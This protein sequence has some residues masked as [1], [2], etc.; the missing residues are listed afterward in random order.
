[1]TPYLPSLSLTSSKTEPN[2]PG[3]GSI[4]IFLPGIGEIQTVYD[5]LNDTRLFGAHSSDFRLIPLHSTL[6]SEEQ[7]LIFKRMQK[8]KIILSTNIAET[9]IT[10]DDVTFVIDCGLSKIKYFDNNKNMESLETAWISRANVAQRKGRSGRSRSG[11]SFHLF[12]RHRFE[13]HLMAQQ[14][15]EIHRIPLE[16]LLLR[17]K[18]LKLFEKARVGDV[19]ARCIEPPTLDNVDGAVKRL[20]NLGALE[21]ERLTPLGSHLAL[22]PVDVRI[23]KLMLFGAIFQCLDSILTIC[24]CLSH[25]SPFVSP[26]TKR[27]EADAR[28]KQFAIGNSDHLTVLNAY[29]RWKEANARSAYAGKVFAEENFLS[30][31]TLE[32]IAEIKQQ[33]VKLLVEI[34]FVPVDLSGEVRRRKKKFEDNVLEVT[35]KMLNANFGNTR[36]ISG[37]LSASLYPNVIKILT[38]EKNYINTI[39]GA[40]PRSFQASEIKFKTKEDGYVALHPSSINANVGVFHSPFLVYQEKVK[41][42]RIFIRD[43][44]MVQVIPLILFSGTDIRIEMHDNEF[45][46]ILEDGWLIVQADSLQTAESMK[47]LRRELMNILNEKIKDPLLNLWNHE[48]GKRVVSAIIHLLTK[49]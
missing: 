3:D 34:G 11:I 2:W 20:Q 19:L 47:Y 23:G 22:L 12:S 5:H 45:L 24:A 38:P 46:F 33:F 4:L 32:T 29:Q 49:E 17:V 44:T 27:Q 21:G 28:K 18:M 35:G 42:S 14:I 26:F 30:L 39:S 8:R 31:N 25:K 9:S 7:S 36:L 37:I 15:P 43:S 6:S 48:N 1:L 16:Q 41:T 10:I 40:L 13:N